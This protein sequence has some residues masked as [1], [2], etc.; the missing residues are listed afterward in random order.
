MV[1]DQQILYRAANE[2]NPI[3]ESDEPF[4]NYISGERRNAITNK[5]QEVDGFAILAGQY[6]V[7]DDD[8]YYDCSFN[9]ATY[10]DN[11]KVALNDYIRYG[12]KYIVKFDEKNNPLFAQYAKSYNLIYEPNSDV[13]IYRGEAVTYIYNLIICKK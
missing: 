5:W 9:A 1:D 8:A 4:F 13:K 2:A 3:P 10:L 12:K 11:A 6:K 7:I